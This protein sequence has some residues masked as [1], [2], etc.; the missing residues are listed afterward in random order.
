MAMFA[1]GLQ[2]ICAQDAPLRIVTNHPDFKI[3]ILRCAA[4]GNTV[5]IN[6][7]FLN[8]G[9]TD[10]GNVKIYVDQFGF[11]YDSWSL[12]AY[13]DEGNIYN[14]G[15]RIQFANYQYAAMIESGIELVAGVPTKVNIKLPN[16]SETASCFPKITF[17]VKNDLWGIGDKPV[18]IRNVPITRD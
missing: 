3:K 11:P 2:N 4:S 17:L 1:F 14:R 15:A 18:E 13:D 8:E 9:A 6:M 16:V 7:V 5:V 12:K 10:S